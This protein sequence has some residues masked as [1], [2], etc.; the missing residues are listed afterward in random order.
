MNT[1]FLAFC[2]AG[3]ESH[4]A[5]LAAVASVARPNRTGHASLQAS[6][7]PQS[8]ASAATL[9]DMCRKGPHPYPPSISYNAAR[10][11]W[12]NPRC[13]ADWLCNRG[14]RDDLARNVALLEALHR[15]GVTKD[16]LRS[17]FD[18]RG[19]MFIHEDS[20]RGSPGQCTHTVRVNGFAY[21][22]CCDS[23]RACANLSADTYV[24]DDEA[25]EGEGN[26]DLYSNISGAYM[27]RMFVQLRLV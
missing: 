16:N 9:P 25:P 17:M 18:A 21:V 26:L 4:L 10:C 7:Q 13:L 6:A 2:C 20:K 19:T 27:L 23:A 8:A 5:T 24:L 11:S 14:D 3:R 12:L 15:P 1:V 22:A